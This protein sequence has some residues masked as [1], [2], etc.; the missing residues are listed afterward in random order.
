MNRERFDELLADALGGELSPADQA[1]FDAF[2]KADANARAEYETLRA[3][4]GNMRQLDAPARVSVSR[5]GDRLVL[6]RSARSKTPVQSTGRFSLAASVL[7]AFLGGYLLHAG[8]MLSRDAGTAPPDP[9]AV[10]VEAPEPAPSLR[11]ALASVHAEHPDYSDF[12]KLAIAM[13][14]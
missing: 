10:I 13:A 3:A 12:A 1:D 2:L 11:S 5:Q 8:L 14:R 7:I 6:D 9:T 4:M